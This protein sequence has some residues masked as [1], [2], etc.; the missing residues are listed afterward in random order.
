MTSDL[1]LH[2]ITHG[3]AAATSAILG[4]GPCPMTL[5]PHGIPTA[6]EWIDLGSVKPLDLAQTF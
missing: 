6:L 1:L 3:D 4:P 5:W 2:P